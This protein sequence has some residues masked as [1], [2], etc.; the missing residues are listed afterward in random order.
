MHTKRYRKLSEELC[1]EAVAKCFA[2]KWRRRDIL[3]FVEEYTGISREEILLD[4]LQTGPSVKHEVVDS[5]AM[6][7]YDLC[8]EII[9]GHT[10]ECVDPVIVKTRPDASTGKMR[11][12]ASLCIPHQLLNHVAVLMLEP[13]FKARILPT[14]HASIPKRGQ[15]SLKK[16]A[17]RYLL[18]RSLGI[19]YRLKTDIKSAYA[20]LKYD[21]VISLIEKECPKAHGLI[22]LLRFLGKMA[23]GGHLIIGG[24]LD[25]WLF[26]F[27]MSYALRYLLSLM[28]KRRDKDI[29]FVIRAQTYMDD[30]V[31]LGASVKNLRTA[32]AKLDEYLD[33]Y[34]DLTLKISS[35]VTEILSIPEEKERRYAS[36]A[37]HGMPQLDMG[38]YRIARTCITIR[39]HIFLRIRRQLL[40]ALEDIRKTGTVPFARACKVMSYNSIILQADSVKLRKKYEVDMIVDICRKVI[41]R[42]AKA[43]YRKRKEYLYDL[44]KRR[45]KQLSRCGCA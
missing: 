13:L 24:Y 18:K 34:F 32:A 23:P 6:F 10:P 38:G 25:A 7:L 17:Q 14:Q 31:L 45:I 40:R 8:E 39:R 28:R 33:E 35:G 4:E 26:N 30:F 19:K 20:S 16:Q 42:Q 5:S 12:I 15:T 44:Q 21:V 36:G 27:A 1:R 22:A 9:M 11:D 3:T 43:E 2:G 41:S 29:P 37:A